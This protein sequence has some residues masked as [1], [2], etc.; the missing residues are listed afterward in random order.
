MHLFRWLH[1]P[2][3]MLVQLLQ[4]SST[5][6]IRHE[7]LFACDCERTLCN[8]QSTGWIEG[9]P[10]LRQS[11]SLKHRQLQTQGVVSLRIA[12]TGDGSNGVPTLTPAQSDDDTK[13]W[14]R[15]VAAIAG[16]V[17]ALLLV[18]IIAVIVYLRIKKLASQTSETES[19]EQ[20]PTELEIV[21][22]PTYASPRLSSTSFLRLLTV[23]ELKL[24]TRSFSDSN[25]IGEGLLGL[26]YKG[27]LLD[28]SIAAIKKNIYHPVPN[29]ANEVGHLAS[30]QNQHLVKLIGYCED[31]KQQFLVSEFISNGNVGQYLY[32]SEGLPIGKLG[33]KQ[34]LSIALDAAKG[35]R[36]LHS[37]VPPFLHLHFRT[38]N[39]LVDENFTAKVSD[40]GIRKLVAETQHPGSSSSVDALLHVMMFLRSNSSR[41]FSV[42]SDVYSYGVFLLELISGREAHGK[43]QSSSDQNLL[44]QVSC[45][46]NS[47]PNK[48]KTVFI[49]FLT[50]CSSI[51]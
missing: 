11:A 45:T 31:R 44:L 38:S 20:S 2:L 36:Y 18:I 25:I 32:D 26:V 22:T 12:K 1:L 48:H 34:R 39:V 13:A 5:V 9:Y 3:F 50:S 8:K 51:S 15:K 17:G 6:Q 19:S 4:L 27:L 24:A 21:E 7:T 40:Y 33:I 49:L 43:Y 42:L 30:V 10:C 29:F 37:L 23:E 28:G 41:D 47:Q 35:L 14:K 16:G 46:D